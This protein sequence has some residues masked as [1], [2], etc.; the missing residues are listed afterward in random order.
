MIINL[1]IL[2]VLAIILLTIWFNYRHNDVK[3]KEHEIDVS[4][5]RFPKGFLWGA[6]TSAH[7]VE[8]GCD[9]NDWAIWERSYDLNA[10]PRIKNGQ[11]SGKAADHW[12]RFRGDIDLLKQIGANSYRFSVEWSKV[13]PQPNKLN[14]SVIDHYIDVCQYLHHSGVNPFVT[15]HHFTIP[16]W[17]YERGGFEN[18]D[19]IHYYTDFVGKVAETLGPYV[20]YWATFNEPVVYAMMGWVFGKFPPGKKD[21][22]LAARVLAN[23]LQA[24]YQAYHI[25]HE[26]DRSDADDDGIPCK[27]GIVKNIPLFDPARKWWLPDW[28]VAKTLHRLFNQSVLDAF[29]AERFK[30]NL[31]NVVNFSQDIPGLSNTL[32]WIGLNYYTQYL[33]RLDWKS[34]YKMRT[35]PNLKLPQTDM[36]W[37]IYPAGLYRSLQMIGSFGIPIYIT[38]NGIATEDSGLRKDFILKHINAMHE[39]MLDRVDVRGYFYWS[40]MD[41]FEWA[42]GFDK[43]FGLYHVDYKTQKRTLKDGSEIYRELIQS[44]Q[45]KQHD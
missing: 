8:G 32:D 18:P 36:N 22:C 9:R 33:C 11:Q 3:W 39:A 45:Y 6:A 10:Y 42:E 21:L 35:Y 44:V 13:C 40:L 27:V 2:V 26:I 34:D 16:D 7:Q 28:I 15:L 12:N 25:L 4:G 14:T 17:L 38:E 41:N 29:I 31:W 37:A 1:V 5:L 43:R 30:F 19:A 24:H 23:I 20:D